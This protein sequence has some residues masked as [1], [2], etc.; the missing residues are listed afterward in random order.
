MG[1]GLGAGGGPGIGGG[2]GLLGPGPVGEGPGIGGGGVPVYGGGVVGPGVVLSTL[3]NS[4]LASLE[5]P[6]RSF[7]TVCFLSLDFV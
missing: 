5:P 7:I 3:A 6:M 4:G 2:G 1:P